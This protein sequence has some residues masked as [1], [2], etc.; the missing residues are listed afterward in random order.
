MKLYEEEINSMVKDFHEQA[1]DMGWWLAHD[2][3]VDKSEPYGPPADTTY[4]Y[5]ATKLL[6]IHSEISE[7]V[8]TTNYP[9]AICWKS[10]WPTL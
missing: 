10:S 6:L 5:V 3:L 2:R 8:K 7:A 1:R 4:Y 9:A